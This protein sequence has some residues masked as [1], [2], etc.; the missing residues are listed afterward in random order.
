M[1]QK[2]N[3][4]NLGR[5][6]SEERKRKQSER[7]S[8]KNHPMYGKTPWNKNIKMWKDK[9]HPFSGCNHTNENKQKISKSMIGKYLESNSSMWKGDKVGYHALHDWIKRRKPKPK[10]CVRCNKRKAYDLANISGKYKRD[11]D[12]FEW[13]CRKCH[14]TKDGRLEK[15]KNGLRNIR[16]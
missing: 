15:M 5:K 7:V 3:K 10:S 8:G 11:V 2:G 6:H 12:D 1:F 4:I 9:K 14:M 16:K 13:L